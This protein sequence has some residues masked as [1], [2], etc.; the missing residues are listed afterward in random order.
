MVY[1]TMK[2][3]ISKEYPGGWDLALKELLNLIIMTRE[4]RGGYVYDC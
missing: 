1:I 2:L 3:R 4:H